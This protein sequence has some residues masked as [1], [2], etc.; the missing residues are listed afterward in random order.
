MSRR[1]GQAHGRVDLGRLCDLRAVGDGQG[2]AG[3]RCRDGGGAHACA[4][5]GAGIGSDVQAQS[6]GQVSTTGGNGA[7]QAGVVDITAFFDRLGVVDDPQSGGNEARA[8][9]SRSSL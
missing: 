6:V 2:G 7:A 4:S 3:G 9:L 1:R 8:G 5:A